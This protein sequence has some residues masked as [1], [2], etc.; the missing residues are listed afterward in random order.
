MNTVTSSRHF[1]RRHQLKKAL[2]IQHFHMSPVG[3]VGERL[4]HHGFELDEYLVVSEEQFHTPNVDFTF[5]NFDDYDLV[6]PMGAPWGA[7]DDGCIGNWLLP[8]LELF[9]RA[10]EAGKPVLGICFGGQMLARALGGSVAPAPRPEL[11]WR[12][13]HSDDES[14]VGPGPW[15]EFHYDRWELPP[16]VQE[17]A[18]S[19][20]ASQA[21][22]TKKTLA[23]QFHPEILSDTLLAWIATG[24]REG[25]IT[26]G[27][28]PELLVAQTRE[29]IPRADL[30]TFDLVDAYLRDIA[31]LID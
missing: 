8:E 23:V 20:S 7:W 13:I 3:A 15:F 21:F 9:R 12:Y 11:G 2:I 5:P 22:T 19:P 24:G 26:D 17:I 28:D 30:R 18:R 4:R 1:S 27:Q 31:G 25:L 10:V 16:G 6:V 29:E 14:V